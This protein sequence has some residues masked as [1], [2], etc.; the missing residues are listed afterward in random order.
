MRISCA[1]I[2]LLISIFCF[3]AGASEI[4]Y[5]F[6]VQPA[7]SASFKKGGHGYPGI[8]IF[9]RKGAAFVSPVSGTVEDVQETDLWEKT[10]DPAMKGGIWLSITGDDGYRYY[11]SHLEGI[12][13]GITVG[14]RVKPGEIL[15]YIG[16][17][18]N[19][20]HTPS[21]LHFGISLASRP[22][23]YIVRRGEIEPYYFLACLRSNRCD[24]RKTLDDAARKIKSR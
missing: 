3:I 13:A 16:A 22:Y 24:P 1:V 11:G 21:H 20:K 5:T 23:S 14:K 6:P 9:A 2:L 19:A 8:D 18:G 15:A 10:R 7:K 12:A 4:S 17:S